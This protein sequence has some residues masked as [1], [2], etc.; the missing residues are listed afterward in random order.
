M[1]KNKSPSALLLRM[2]CSFEKTS[3]LHGD[4]RQIRQRL[5][6]ARNPLERPSNLKQH[7]FTSATL[8]S[9][10][11][12]MAHTELAHRDAYHSPLWCHRRY[13]IYSILRA[14]NIHC[15][16][17]CYCYCCYRYYYDTVCHFSANRLAPETDASSMQAPSFDREKQRG[18]TA[19]YVEHTDSI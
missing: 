9:L 12:T 19:R 4:M 8:E 11:E 5:T 10:G 18:H 16:H 14:H 2:E 3:T 15:R 13:A 7:K 17:Y 6:C 1:A